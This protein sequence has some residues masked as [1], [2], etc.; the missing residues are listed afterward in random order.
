MR[1]ILIAL[2]FTAFSVLA[3]SK[4]E[5]NDQMRTCFKEYSVKS[6]IMETDCH[7]VTEFNRFSE[8]L[9]EIPEHVLLQ[10]TFVPMFFLKSIFVGLLPK[11]ALF[12]D[13][14]L[15]DAYSASAVASKEAFAHANMRLMESRRGGEKKLKR[16]FDSLLR[17]IKDLHLPESFVYEKKQTSVEKVLSL[18]GDSV[19]CFIK[20]SSASTPRSDRSSGSTDISQ[21]GTVSSARASFRRCSACAAS[22]KAVMESSVVRSNL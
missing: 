13:V 4:K 11:P 3:L 6:D 14:V 16:V 7:F 1:L 5:I 8:I 10:L 21:E 17:S 22:G 18:E 19:S 15:R 9:S 2:F 12:E 20:N